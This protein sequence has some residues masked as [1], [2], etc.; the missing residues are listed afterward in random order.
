MVSCKMVHISRWKVQ[1][2]VTVG[3]LSKRTV[4]FYP[5]DSDDSGTMMSTSRCRDWV[6]RARVT[7]ENT[8]GGGGGSPLSRGGGAQP[9]ILTHIPQTY[10]V[11]R[12]ASENE[13]EVAACAIS[14]L[15]LCSASLL[16]WNLMCLEEEPKQPG[17][18]SCSTC[19][20]TLCRSPLTQHRIGVTGT[21]SP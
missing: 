9:S 10:T 3:N 11:P 4:F 8:V 16:H 20:K 12:V 6:A 18:C 14:R 17:S 2:N 13:E 15:W 19:V 1:A 21:S 7:C 5:L